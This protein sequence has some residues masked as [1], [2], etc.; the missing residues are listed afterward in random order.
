MSNTTPI[1]DWIAL[2]RTILYEIAVKEVQAI[3]HTLSIKGQTRQSSNGHSLQAE[4]LRV[5]VRNRTTYITIEWLVRRWF[6]R[7]GRP[8]F[9]TVT[10]RKG[11]GYRYSEATLARHTRAADLSAVLETESRFADIRQRLRELKDL[12]KLL[13]KTGYTAP[14]QEQKRGEDFE[15]F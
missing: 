1:T 9:A 2:Q 13:A 12:E 10:L 4:E 6:K 14:H 7:D 8:R 3:Q 11:R 15:G 5:R